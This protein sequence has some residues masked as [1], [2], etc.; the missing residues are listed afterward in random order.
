MG[1]PQESTRRSAEIWCLL[2]LGLVLGAIVWSG[3]SPEKNYEVLSFFF[4]GVPDPNAPVL[5][6][7]TGAALRRSPTYSIHKPF[8]EERCAE[9]H[10][11]RFN[12]GPEDSGICLKCHEEIT[13][14]Q[15]MMHGPVV[16]GA[17]LWCHAAHES[18]FEWLL[19]GEPRQV[20]TDCH[21]QDLLGIGRVPAH[22][23][24]TR[25]CLECHFGHGGT[26][27]YFLR[28]AV[29]PVPPA[30]TP[31]PPATTPQA[32]EGPTP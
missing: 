13:S 26:R 32:S 16:A 12:L 1:R 30:N 24:E 21:D 7:A 4:D 19:K 23:D 31:E 22:A 25:G 27:R 9:C 14:Q 29:E 28:E 17:C 2:T 5:A 10:G 11:S 6:T 20:C 18:A 15:P 8:Q 3:C